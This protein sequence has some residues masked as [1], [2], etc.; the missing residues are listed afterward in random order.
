MRLRLIPVALGLALLICG[1]VA[2]A[3][4]MLSFVIDGDTFFD[5]FSMT[6]TSDGGETVTGFR[7]DIA[8]AGL[9]Y[10]TVN[11]G[12]GIPNGVA[13]APAGGTDVTT[14]LLLTPVVVPDGATLLSLSFGGFDP[15]ETFRWNID[16]DPAG[17]GDPSIY[18]NEMIGALAYVD[19]SDGQTL[20][21]ILAAVPGNPNASQFTVT[22]IVPTD[23]VPEPGTLLLLGSGL[24]GFAARRRRRG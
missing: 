20:E 22:G 10:D 11:G 3:T 21:G 23:P 24:V 17:G 8:P 2:E 5:P 7:L 14:G 12:P 13:F 6:N 18:G 1:P 15:G 19:F 9:I 4:P 16:V